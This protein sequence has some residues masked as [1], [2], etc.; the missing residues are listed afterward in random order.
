MARHIR[1]NISFVRTNLDSV[2]NGIES[3]GDRVTVVRNRHN[4]AVIMS[5]DEYQSLTQAFSDLEAL[6]AAQGRRIRLHADHLFTASGE[7]TEC[8]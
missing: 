4:S 2:L 7:C 8:D 6:R 3:D 1:Y 5:A